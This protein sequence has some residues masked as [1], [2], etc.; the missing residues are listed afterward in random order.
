MNSCWDY[1]F[2]SFLQVVYSL[3]PSEAGYVGNIFNIGS[4]FFAVPVGL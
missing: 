1:Y 4:C 2:T 3:S